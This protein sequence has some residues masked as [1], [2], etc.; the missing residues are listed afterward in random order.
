MRIDR[1]RLM[2]W[3]ALYY[4]ASGLSPLISMEFFEKITGRKHD[5]WLVQTV[6]LLAAAIGAS[7]WVSSQSEKLEPSALVLSNTSAL[8]FAGID[9]VHVARGRISPVY[10][11]DAAVE[12]AILALTLQW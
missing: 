6:G 4:C 12:L 9:V 8:A 3:Q 7:L 5:R 10:L 11:A 1:R 2:R